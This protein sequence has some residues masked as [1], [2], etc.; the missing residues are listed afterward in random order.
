MSHRFLA[1][2][3]SGNLRERSLNKVQ[4]W[5]DDTEILPI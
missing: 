5:L 4:A 3:S 2:N 1:K